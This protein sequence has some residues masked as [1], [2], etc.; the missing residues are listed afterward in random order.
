MW[1]QMHELSIALGIVEAAQEE[2]AKRGAPRVTAVH[3]KLGPLSGV[4]KDALEFS[5]G[6]ACADTTLQGS[7]LVIEETRIMTL[8]ANC[9]ERRPVESLQSFRCAV[10]ETPATEIVEGRELQLVALEIE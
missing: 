8:C 10:C 1:A 2:A 6:V 7:R 4:V 3:L 9:G 5:Y